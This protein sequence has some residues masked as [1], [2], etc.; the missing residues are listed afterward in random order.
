M[1]DGR[2]GRGAHED[3]G[4][5][6]AALKVSCALVNP[7]GASGGQVKLDAEPKAGGEGAVGAD[8]PERA[9][10][11]DVAEDRPARRAA[12]AAHE[13][14]IAGRERRHERRRG[15]VLP[16]RAHA[17]HAR[18][19]E[20]RLRKGRR[21]RRRGQQRLAEG[22]GAPLGHRGQLPLRV[23]RQRCKRLRRDARRSLHEHEQGV[24]RQAARCGAR[25]AQEAA[26]RGGDGGSPL[27]AKRTGRAAATAAA[28]AAAVARGEQRQQQLLRGARTTGHRLH[29]RSAAER[30]EERGEGIV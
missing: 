12:R 30:A 7:V 27:A 4:A 22:R 2:D 25:V 19:D 10:M 24:A 17:A 5:L 29:R 26:E 28:A 11:A 6:L 18:L 16:P 21:R 3:T 1:G 15:R 9:Q 13:Q 20:C 14:P 8:E 23:Q